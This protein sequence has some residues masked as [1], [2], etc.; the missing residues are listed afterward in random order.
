VYLLELSRSFVSK[1][2]L[3]VRLTTV[4]PLVELVIWYGE[5]DNK[6]NEYTEYV[7]QTK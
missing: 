1:I 2:K 5:G 3:C 6:R 4:A 7:L